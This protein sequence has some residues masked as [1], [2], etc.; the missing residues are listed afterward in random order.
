M[1][2]A[3][4]P[5]EEYDTVEVQRGDGWLRGTVI[6]TVLARCHVMLED[7][8]LTVVDDYHDIRRVEE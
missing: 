3:N 2:S 4:N 1:A 6:K 8:M 7:S 5:F